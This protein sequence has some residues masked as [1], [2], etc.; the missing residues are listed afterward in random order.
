MLTCDGLERILQMGD[1]PHCRTL[2]LNN[3]QTENEWNVLEFTVL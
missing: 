3:K 1:R 2:V